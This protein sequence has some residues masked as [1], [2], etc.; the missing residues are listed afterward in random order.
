MRRD[1]PAAGAGSSKGGADQS[2]LTRSSVPGFIPDTALTRN[3]IGLGTITVGKVA[4]TP[5]DSEILALD[6]G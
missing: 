5:I 6:A 2:W 3:K 4:G 1:A